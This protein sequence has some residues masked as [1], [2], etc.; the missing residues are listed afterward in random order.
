MSSQNAEYEHTSPEELRRPRA[1]N[2]AC[3][4]GAPLPIRGEMGL[5]CQYKCLINEDL[6]ILRGG[7]LL[8]GKHM[9]N[10]MMNR[11]GYS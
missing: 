8:R 10:Q 2:G 1:G 4:Q 5:N 9:A 11:R 6:V 3:S 7:I